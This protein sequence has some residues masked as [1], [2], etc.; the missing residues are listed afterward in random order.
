MKT[1]WGACGRRGELGGDGLGGKLFPAMAGATV[2]S[3]HPNAVVRRDIGCSPHYR[4]HSTSTCT[5]VP[6][7]DF[8]SV[9]HHFVLDFPNGFARI[10]LCL[11]LGDQ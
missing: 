7:T 6:Q 1:G 11:T 2:P 10:H 4:E 8:C 3:R 9:E 5:L